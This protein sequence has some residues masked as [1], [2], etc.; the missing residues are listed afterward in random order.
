M[1]VGLGWN[2]SC[3]VLEKYHLGN[4]RTSPKVLSIIISCFVFHAIHA[5]PKT[6]VVETRHCAIEAIIVQPVI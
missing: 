4:F 5:Y 6:F 2:I 1:S 3:C